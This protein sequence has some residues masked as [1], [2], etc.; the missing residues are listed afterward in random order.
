MPAM[1]GVVLAQTQVQRALA[2]ASQLSQSGPGGP[3]APTPISSAA[4][5]TASSIHRALARG[6]RGGADAPLSTS[7]LA[8]QAGAA[9]GWHGRGGRSS[10]WKAPL[11]APEAQAAPAHCRYS[12]VCSWLAGRWARSRRFPSALPA[13]S[14]CANVHTQ[15]A[16]SAP[17]GTI[18]GSPDLQTTGGLTR[19]PWEELSCPSQS[20]AGSD[21]CSLA[22]VASGGTWKQASGLAPGFPGVGAL[23][24]PPPPLGCLTATSRA[25]PSQPHASARCQFLHVPPPHFLL[26]PT[27]V[28][29]VALCKSSNHRTALHCTALCLSRMP[30]PE[31]SGKLIAFIPFLR[32][33]AKS[34]PSEIPSRAAT[35]AVAREANR[36]GDDAGTRPSQLSARGRNR[37]PPRGVRAA[38]AAAAFLSLRSQRHK[39]PPPSMPQYTSRDVGDPSQIKKNKQS[40]ADLK[41][42]RLT[43]LNNRLREDLERERIPVSTAAKSIIA[44]C[45]GTRDY[46]VPSVWGAVPKGE[47]PYAPQQSGDTNNKSDESPRNDNYD[48]FLASD[49]D[50]EGAGRSGVLAALMSAEHFKRAVEP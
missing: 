10:N 19:R 3:P 24:A 50:E 18:H 45:N 32:P 20:A 47:D 28:P 48:G 46:M 44:Y 12:L 9:S 15:S 26:S 38:I 14:S 42:R 6:L 22:G 17:Q 7:S 21:Y 30:R 39:P 31:V 4:T 8:G 1:S 5:G 16:E 27:S 34:I 35:A 37:T 29:F 41:L 2:G 43:E 40:M 23:G 36:G 11:A 33:V 13:C 25:E 49:Q